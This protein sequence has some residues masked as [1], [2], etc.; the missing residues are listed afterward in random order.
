MKKYFLS[1]TR[2]SWLVYVALAATIAGGVWLSVVQRRPSAALSFWA[3]LGSIALTVGP[4]IALFV[5]VRCP[6]CG[7]RLLWRA[8]TSADVS[9]WLTGVLLATECPVCH[10]VP[11]G[12]SRP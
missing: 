10:Y 9:S 5:L 12:H 6:R 1:A 7:T 3:L 11:D 4:F 2:Q 8:A